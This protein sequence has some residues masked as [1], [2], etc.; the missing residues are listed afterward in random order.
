MREKKGPKL[1]ALSPILRSPTRLV[2]ITHAS[3]VASDL[4]GFER[5]V[6]ELVHVL[7]EHHVAVDQDQ[8]LAVWARRS[9]I[10]IV[11]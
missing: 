4:I 1:E 3:K 2:Q 8:S 10:S 7:L 9:V 11:P 5:D 6:E